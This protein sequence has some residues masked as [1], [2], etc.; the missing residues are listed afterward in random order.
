MNLLI[1]IIRKSVHQLGNLLRWGQVILLRAAGVKVGSNCMISFRAK[2]DIRRGKIIIGNNCTITYGC[3]I[4]SH[5]RS[6]MHINPADDGYGEVIIGNN[7]YI[8]VNSVIL[9]NVKIGDNSVI[10]AGSVVNVDI[11]PN[12]VAV[13]NPVKV[14][15]TLN[16]FE[17]EIETMSHGRTVQR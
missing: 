1:T 17:K 2:I 16:R 4:I 10:G 6:A 8:G 13:G 3:V 9:R 15:K 5:D 12:V 11:P 14:V 7:V